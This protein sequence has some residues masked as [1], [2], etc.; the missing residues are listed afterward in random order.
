MRQNFTKFT[1]E[2]LNKWWEEY[3]EGWAGEGSGPEKRSAVL[4][5]EIQRRYI[6]TQNIANKELIFLTRILVFL[7]IVLMIIAGL[8]TY[9]LFTPS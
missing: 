4:I 5:A 7:T 8:Q 3:V 9:K 6:K 1:D 2:E